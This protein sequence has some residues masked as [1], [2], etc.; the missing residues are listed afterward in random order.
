MRGS[1]ICNTKIHFCCIN[2]NV[3]ETHYRIFPKEGRGCHEMFHLRLF[4]TSMHNV[5]NGLLANSVSIA[6][7]KSIVYQKVM[8]L[9]QEARPSVHWSYSWLILRVFWE[10]DFH[11]ISCSFMHSHAFTFLLLCLGNFRGFRKVSRFKPSFFHS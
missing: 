7:F 1:P 4:N 9:G 10:T 5:P 2:F 3:Y 6:L 8:I 11:I